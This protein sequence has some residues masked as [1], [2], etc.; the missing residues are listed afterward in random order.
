MAVTDYLE[1]GA[2]IEPDGP[3]LLMGERCYTYREVSSLVC[4]VANGLLAAGYGLGRHAA[5]LC[6]ND[7]H[8]YACT[9]GIMRAGMTY[10][11]LDFRNSSADNER[12]LDFSDSEVLFY[13]SGFHEQVEALRPRLPKLRLLVCIDRRMGEAPGLQEWAAAF[14]ESEPRV[15]VPAEAIAWLQA[16]SGTTGDF[17]MAMMSHRAYHAFVAFQQIWLPDPAP[18]MLVAAPIT[19]A[20]GGLSYQVLARGGRL[21]LLEKPDPQAVLRTIEEQRITQ[22]FLPPTVIYRLL[23]Q[24][25]VREFDYGSLEYLIY[26]A[27]P[28]SVEKLK[29][30][31]EVFGPVMAQAYG[32]TEV[33]G[34]ANMTPAEHHAGGKVAPDA[35]LSACGRPGLPFCKVAIMGE[36]NEPLPRGEAGEICVRGDQ[37]MSGYYKNPIATRATIIDGW[38]HTGDIGFFDEEGY[39]HIV[40]RKKDMVISGGFNVYPAEVEQ[41]IASFDAVRECAVIGVPDAEWGEVVKAVVE[42]SPGRT[43]S[44]QEI[45]ARCRERLGSVKAPK[46]VDFVVELPRN[47]RG[48]VLKR[49]LRD[50][51]WKGRQRR[52]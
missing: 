46:S 47:V 49:V 50:E 12:I 43:L 32:Q 42:L 19:H 2:L 14:A 8:G 6:A 39:L 13:Q 23:E 41:V 24:P 18:V 17:R 45:I 29:L 44:A 10:V 28:M 1:R 36:G 9:L 21:V 5:V 31:L 34:I 20:A 15:Q 3:C 51:Y 26:S 40:D 27:A 52:V 7:P 11:P 16:G 22:V 25:N 4:R 38:A 33:L 37:V 48:K 35:R 30:A